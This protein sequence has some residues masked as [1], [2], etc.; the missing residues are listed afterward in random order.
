MELAS[1]KSEL[2]RTQ[3]QNQTL[4]KQ[5]TAVKDASAKLQG[6]LDKVKAEVTAMRAEVFQSSRPGE[7]TQD[8]SHQVKELLDFKTALS[9]E[10]DVQRQRNENAVKTIRRLQKELAERSPAM[11]A[12]SP[13]SAEPPPAA[14]PQQ[15]EPSQ[16]SSVPPMV[17]TETA[18]PAPPAKFKVGK[19]LAL[20]GK[21]T[22]N[23]ANSTVIKALAVKDTLYDLDLIR[24][25]SASKLKIRLYDGTLFTL[26]E[27]TVLEISDSGSSLQRD[28]RKTLFTL[29]S[30]AFRAIVNKVSQRGTMVV[31]TPTAVATVRGTDWA[32]VAKPD[33]TGILVIKGKVAVTNQDPDIKGEVLVADGEGTDVKADQPPWKP[34]PWGQA[35]VDALLKATEL[36]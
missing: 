32:A 6:E 35:R 28:Q 3:A 24:T 13:P 20:T 12:P 15:P 8:S 7:G 29:A 16:F 36:K 34:K 11:S 10:L 31:Q 1:T 5:M 17:Q 18:A 4:A 33:S 25:D 30:G 23:H 14:A 27:G 22:V 21:V 2:N 26:A 9:Q 19:V